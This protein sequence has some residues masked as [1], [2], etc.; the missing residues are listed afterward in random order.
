MSG[1]FRRRAGPADQRRRVPGQDP[2][3][4]RVRVIDP[5]GHRREPDPPPGAG[6]G[7]FSVDVYNRACGLLTGIHLVDGMLASGTVKLGMVVASHMDPEPG[8]SERFSVPGVGGAVLLQ[9]DDPRGGFTAFQFVT[10]P[11]FAELFRELRRLARPRWERTGAPRP[12]HPHRRDRRVLH[13]PRSNARSR[14]PA[15]SP[16]DKLDLNEIDLIIA[17]ASVPGFADGLAI[18]L[19]IPTT[20]VATL[21]GDLAGAH[22]ATPALALLST[23][24]IA[25]STA[26]FIS[27]GAGS[28]SPSTRHNQW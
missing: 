6:H 3:R 26:L 24:L 9:A 16:V 28:P 19:G 8:I 1:V 22:I 14:P 10:F 15:N 20:A 18:R 11:Q 13:H 5:G 4:A 12:K 21:P 7:T 25:G 17:T 23:D 27:A 2:Q